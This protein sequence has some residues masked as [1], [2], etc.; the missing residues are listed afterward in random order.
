MYLKYVWGRSRLS[1]GMNDTHVLSYYE[2]KNGIPEA[3]T[4]FFELD[5]GK[6]ENDEDLRV[7]LLYGVENCNEIA[8]TG[9]AYRLDADFGME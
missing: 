8:E 5:L 7:K 9:S 6:Y 2:A 1:P 3:H 4:C